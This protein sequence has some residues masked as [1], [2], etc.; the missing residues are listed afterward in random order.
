MFFSGNSGK[1]Y[2]GAEVKHEIYFERPY[3]EIVPL[4]HWGTE[5]VR[6]RVP[7]YGQSNNVLLLHSQL[8]DR[9]RPC[10]IPALRKKR[11]PK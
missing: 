1:R 7:Y 5:I 6:L 3:Y 8:C 9:E 10:K 11:V 4:G 2:E